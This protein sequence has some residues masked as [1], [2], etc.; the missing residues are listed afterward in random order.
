MIE[1]P[2]LRPESRYG[3]PIADQLLFNREYIIGYSYLFRQARWAMEVIDQ[4]NKAIEI[5]HRSDAFRADLRIPPKFRADLEDFRK[6]DHDR[7][8]LVSSAD[9]RASELKNSETFLLSNMSPQKG[10]FNRQIWRLLEDDVRNLS[11]DF[12]EVYVICGPLFDVGKPIEVIGDRIHDADKNEVT[13]PVPHAYFKSVLAED[14][15]GRVSLWSFIMENRKLNRPRTDFLVPTS[16][17]ERRAGLSLWDRLRGEDIEDLKE[18][19]RTSAQRASAA[20]KFK[21]AVE[22]GAAAA[23]K[24]DAKRKELAAKLGLVERGEVTELLSENPKLGQ[25]LVDLKGASD[26]E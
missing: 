9:R 24:K 7:G 5:D 12:V 1:I 11:F 13:I 10:D 6:S 26:P 8:H 21:A 4:N 15:K 2:S 14:I 22:R 23:K 25:L 3:I 17:V 16:E 19:P 20:R 18:K